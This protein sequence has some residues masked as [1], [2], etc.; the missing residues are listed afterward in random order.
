MNPQQ[1]LLSVIVPFYNNEA[2]VIAALDS[3]FAQIS[4]DIEV[5]IIDDGSTD[6]SGALV[7]QYLAQR[8]HPRVVFTSQANGGIAHAR[9]VGLRLATGRYI[10]FL[11]GDDLLS[12]DYLA[13]LR[14]QLTAGEYDLIDFNYQKFT[15][16]PPTPD[17]RAARPVAYD[18][19]WWGWAACNRFSNARCG[20]SGAGYINARC[21]QG[22]R[23]K[24]AGAT[25]T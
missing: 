21:W 8:R 13:I 22:K 6:A 3:L 16:H 12:D 20:I 7:S 5:V 9:N 2:F 24:K 10:T 14:P 25:K 17:N 18:F 23:S 1:P 19:S 15:E 4:D 11:D